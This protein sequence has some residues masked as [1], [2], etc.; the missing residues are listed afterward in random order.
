MTVTVDTIE[1]LLVAN[2]AKHNADYDSA[3][4]AAQRYLDTVKGGA[5][6][7]TGASATAAS[8]EQA[9]TRITR[10]RKARTDDEIANAE[11]SRLAELARVNAIKQ[12]VRDE[13]AAT[14]QAEKDK[15]AAIAA[16]TAAAVA[17]AEKQTAL[18]REQRMAAVPVPTIITGG[19]NGNADHGAK[20]D[21]VTPSNGFTDAE[22]GALAASSAPAEAE[23]AAEKEINSLAVDRIGTQAR[24]TAAKGEERDILKDQ[25]LQIRLISQYEKAGLD[26]QAAAIRAD[27]DLLAIDKLRAENQ[28]RQAAAQGSKDILKFGEAAG[29]GRTGGGTAAIAGLAAA[30]AV[31]ISVEAVK[32]ATDYAKALTDVSREAGISTTALQVYQHAAAETGVTAEQFGTALG[33]LSN[34]LG[35]ARD[36]SV[37]EGKVFAALGVD[38]KNGATAGELL[39]T[40]IDRISSI[41]DQAQRASVEVDLFG[42]S[43]KALDGLLSGGNDKVN[44]LADALQRTGS[45]LSPADIAKLDDVSKKLEQVKAQLQ[46]DI[47]QVV[48]GNADAI[49]TLAQSFADLARDIEKA[50][51]IY[52]SFRDFLNSGGN[53]S[54]SP[55]QLGGEVRRG[56]TGFISDEVKNDPA[57]PMAALRA[58][59][60]IKTSGEDMMDSLNA[61][62]PGQIANGDFAPVQPGKVNT[63]LLGSLN[64]KNPPKGKSA[65]TLENERL[66]REKQFND[67]LATAQDGELKAQAQ[68]TGD[69]NERAA[70]ESQ[71]AEEALKRRLA[72]IET[73]RKTNINKGEDPKEAN[74]RAAQLVTAATAETAAQEAAREQQVTFDLAKAANQS[75]QTL[76]GIQ[77]DDLHNRLGLADTSKERLAIELQLLANAKEQERNRLNTVIATSKPGDPAIADAQ[78]QLGALDAN[79]AGQA[80]DTRRANESPGQA[81]ER[82]LKSTSDTVED[83]GVNALKSLNTE[84]DQSV[85]KATHLHG[86]FGNIVDE[87][88]DMAIKQALIK[89]L[90]SAFFGPAGSSGGGLLGQATGALSGGGGGLLGKLGS[91]LGLGGNSGIDVAGNSAGA[92]TAI[93][94]LIGGLSIPGFAGGGSINVGG[95]GG[96]DNNVMSINGKPVVRVNQGERIDV[97]PAG[98][99]SRG[100]AMTLQQSIYVD[101]RNSVTPNEFAGQILDQAADHANRVAAQSGRN[102]VAAAPARVQQ[103]QTL[104]N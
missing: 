44:Q 45:I 89:P 104:G 65:E 66:A 80:A 40:L 4:A 87:L 88:I 55:S 50:F 62:L 27:A 11:R 79:Y 78:K 57:Q 48:A 20:S 39:P 64:A 73:Q 23:V 31:G 56:V 70:I 93:S 2:V 95:L 96:V 71:L 75:A 3:T 74:S 35:K 100:G 81:Y 99:M 6:N 67:Q 38:I 22:L 49:K 51:D 13:A 98:Q 54:F 52:K 16:T 24:L 36:G 5:A 8:E 14:V 58:K 91:L 97:V 90:A 37:Q 68:I 1:T 18:T 69:I 34:N 77:A 43:G 15:Q 19:G 25:A 85:D 92:N 47:A 12:G 21:P 72:D 26:T 29:I 61:R 10:T 76:L 53:S 41:K 33:M 94:S 32:S 28:E 42:R 82:S 63:G 83:A 46:V 84:L 101:G 59:L 102:A 9:T 103:A 60:G 17:A 86:I 7:D 30:G